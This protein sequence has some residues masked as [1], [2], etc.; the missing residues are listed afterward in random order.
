MRHQDFNDEHRS[1]K[2][3]EERSVTQSYS[4]K[5]SMPMPFY[6]LTSLNQENEANEIR[7]SKLLPNKALPLSYRP[8]WIVLGVLLCLITL[9]AVCYGFLL[10]TWNRIKHIMAAKFDWDKDTQTFWEIFI[11]ITPVLGMIIGRILGVPIVNKGRFRCILL[12]SLVIIS[13]CLIM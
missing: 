6:K 13:G 11:N 1:S 7:T 5:Q 8:D 4:Q 2:N 9:V 3:Q 10:G 12:G